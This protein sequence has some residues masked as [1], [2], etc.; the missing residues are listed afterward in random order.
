MS[1]AP[2]NPLGIVPVIAAE[3]EDMAI[4]RLLGR[5]DACFA[6]IPPF[7]L[8]GELTTGLQIEASRLDDVTEIYQAVTAA[9]RFPPPLL[10]K[11]LAQGR[12]G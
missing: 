4:L 6:I 7:V 12:F 2:I 10:S 3:V 5:E 8:Q 11:V 9:C 1:D